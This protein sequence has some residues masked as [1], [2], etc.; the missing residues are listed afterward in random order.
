M[1]RAAKVA[2]W[3][4]L[5]IGGICCAPIYP[6]ALSMTGCKGPLAGLAAR[7]KPEEPAA[8]AGFCRVSSSTIAL[9]S[10]CRRRQLPCAVGTAA[11]AVAGVI[12]ETV[13][14]PPMVPFAV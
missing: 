4:I 11:R 13:V 6:E 12:A 10:P 2:A 7:V 9:Q 5:P 8:Q 14:M 3:L 1:A